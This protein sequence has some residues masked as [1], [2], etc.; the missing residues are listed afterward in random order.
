MAQ[1]LVDG[2]ITEP[3]NVVAT[4]NDDNLASWRLVYKEVG[5]AQGVYSPTQFFES[6]TI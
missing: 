4:I 5:T 2:V 3:T 6:P 1:P